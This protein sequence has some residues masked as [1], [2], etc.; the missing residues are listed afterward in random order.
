MKKDPMKTDEEDPRR[1]II[2]EAKEEESIPSKT[3]QRRKNEDFSCMPKG[4]NDDKCMPTNE[5]FVYT[6]GLRMD[7]L[8]SRFDPMKSDRPKKTTDQEPYKKNR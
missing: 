5:A 8:L 2:Q 3:A 4:L 7:R 1:T 6:K